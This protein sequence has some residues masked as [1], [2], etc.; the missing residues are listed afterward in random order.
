M[1]VWIL[2][3][4]T[5]TSIVIEVSAS[6]RS[7]PFCARSDVLYMM[8]D[9]LTRHILLWSCFASIFPLCIVSFSVIHVYAPLHA[10]LYFRH[11]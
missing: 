2:I 3:V 10:P 8:G 1:R 6:V 5:M 7:D 11:I 4:I 9:R